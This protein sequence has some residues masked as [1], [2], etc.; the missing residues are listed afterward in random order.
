[1]GPKAPH[2]TV[3]AAEEE[4]LI[5]AFRR[6]TLLPLDDCLYALQATIPHLTRSS[7]HR[8]FQ[9]HAINRLPTAEGTRPRRKFKAY[10]MGYV[11]VDFAEVWTEEGRLFLFVAVDRVTKF[12][13]AELH[14]QATR[15]TAAEFLRRLIER[16]PYA[17]HTVL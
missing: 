9:R 3:L 13:F 4:A 2:S 16:M 7:L 5:V 8:L 11:H 15:R 17:I 6:Q 10:P 1:M 12:A 14:R